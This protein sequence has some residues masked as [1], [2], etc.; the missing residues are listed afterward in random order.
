MII[1]YQKTCV[2]RSLTLTIPLRLEN[3][4]SK[5][6]L[7]QKSGTATDWQTINSAI[8][9]K[10][11]FKREE[12]TAARYVVNLSANHLV[13]GIACNELLDLGLVGRGEP[14]N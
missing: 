2:L 10:P 1:S 6:L 4:E 8:L 11:E 14:I 7:D 12:H 13:L 3:R 5:S 9:Q